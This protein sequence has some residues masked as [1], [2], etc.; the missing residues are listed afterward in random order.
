MSEVNDN[1]NAGTVVEQAATVEVAASE[2]P[3][4]KEQSSDVKEDVK[5]N[6]E[7][8]APAKPITDEEAAK[9][10]AATEHKVSRKYEA[11][12][13]EYEKKLAEVSRPPDNESVYDDII[14]W[15]PKNMPVEEYRQRVQEVAAQKA[16]EEQ[17][18][19]LYGN[20]EERAQAVASKFQDFE[21]TLTGAAHLG[22]VT[23]AMVLAAG[24]EEG[25]LEALYDL[26]KANSP[27]L[28]EIARLPE[29][30][31]VKEVYKLA[32]AKAAKPE[33]KRTSADDP[34]KADPEQIVESR[35]YQDMDISQAGFKEWQK[36][37][38]KYR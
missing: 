27:K 34:I 26:A 1:V 37:R 35:S 15:R 16:A 36:Q 11:K 24:Q 33:P 38:D 20:V 29:H 19:Q 17:N 25:G 12:L 18:S 10:R 4:I 8:H 21:P 22:K 32:W 23:P 30:L 31:Q 7:A 9:I 2:A 14:G 5:P 3:E 28:A 13:A 6:Q